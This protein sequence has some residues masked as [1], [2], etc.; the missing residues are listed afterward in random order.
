MIGFKSLKFID[1][2]LTPYGQRPGTTLQRRA[3]SR[4]GVRRLTLA[5]ERPPNYT[6]NL[7]K[8]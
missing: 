7:V 3:F 5:G 8:V 6:P 2:L 1:R 4:S